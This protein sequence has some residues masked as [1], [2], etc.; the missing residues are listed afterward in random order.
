VEIQKLRSRAASSEYTAPPGLKFCWDCGSTNRPRLTALKMAVCKDL[1]A[2]D[3][4]N[5]RCQNH[6]GMD[7]R[8]V[9]L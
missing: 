8:G 5:C 2:P 9:N 4:E 1:A 3:K 6:F 7:E